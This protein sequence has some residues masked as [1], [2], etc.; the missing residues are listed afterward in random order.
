MVELESKTLPQSMDRCVCWLVSEDMTG[1]PEQLKPGLRPCQGLLLG[2][3]LEGLLPVARVSMF[4]EGFLTN[5][6]G[7]R[8][9]TKQSD[10]AVSRS[11][12]GIT[13]SD[14]VTWA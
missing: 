1:G 5:R 9:N 14:P 7:G 6:L 4:L 2:S 3:R 11:I 8:N 13:V 10:Q 12:S